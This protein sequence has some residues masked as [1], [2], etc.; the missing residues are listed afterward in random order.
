MVDG[1][2]SNHQSSPARARCGP[3]AVID[4]IVELISRVA[5]VAE[6]PDDVPIVVASPGPVNLSNDGNCGALGEIRFRS[7]R[8]VRDLIK[9]APAR[10]MLAMY[11]FVDTRTDL[12]IACSSLGKDTVISG[13]EA[14]ALSSINR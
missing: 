12:T 9:L 13:A 10:Q 14:L 7:A 4:N 2:M 3:V 1:V 5:S 8:V 6:L 11:C